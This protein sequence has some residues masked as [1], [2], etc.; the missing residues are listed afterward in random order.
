MTGGS[1]KSHDIGAI[2]AKLGMNEPALR[3]ALSRML[4]H[5]RKT[6]VHEVRDT[7]EHSENVDAEIAHLMS[8]M[9]QR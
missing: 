5:Y 9:G 2:A 4:R 7:V 3:T 1:M 8:V 6:L